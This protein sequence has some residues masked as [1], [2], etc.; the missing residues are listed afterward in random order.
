MWLRYP[1]LCCLH[2]GRDAEYL[3]VSI[4]YN[5]QNSKSLRRRRRGQIEQNREKNTVWVDF[6][7]FPYLVWGSYSP[8]RQDMPLHDA[9]L[10]ALVHATCPALL[11][12]LDLITPI[13]FVE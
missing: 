9:F 13:I 4:S 12:F 6:Q 8:D 3:G 7:T 5:V 10:S 1:L 2:L 11:I